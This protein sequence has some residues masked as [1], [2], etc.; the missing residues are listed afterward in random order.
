MSTE[1]R[2]RLSA[3]LDRWDDTDLTTLAGLL[4][5]LNTDLEGMA[6]LSGS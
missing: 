3:V 1:R 5:R 4:D 6:P 2:A